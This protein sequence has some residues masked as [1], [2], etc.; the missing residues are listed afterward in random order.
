MSAALPIVG[1]H[2]L[3][4]RVKKY[5]AQLQQE[6][7]AF[8]IQV[9]EQAN[10]RL[11]IARADMARAALEH[12]VRFTRLHETR[13]RVIS[14]VYRRTEDLHDAIRAMGS[15]VQMLALEFGE[16]GPPPQ[17]S[18]DHARTERFRLANAALRARE[19][20]DRYF[21]RRAPWL[22][23]D[24]ER[25]VQGVLEMM[26]AAELHAR[27]GTFDSAMI[28]EMSDRVSEATRA[29]QP[30]LALLRSRF[31]EILAAAPMPTSGPR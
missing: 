14:G 28:R 3:T 18:I 12:Q 1:R 25:A 29:I 19:E 8:R 2:W 17:S 30:A 27:V 5:E 22:D 9:Q 31:R 23:E 10:A 11:E 7:D 4:T 15:Q 6:L 21:R 13:A 16:L 20:L 24:T 26:M